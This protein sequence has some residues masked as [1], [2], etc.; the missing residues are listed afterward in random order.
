MGRREY[1]TKVINGFLLAKVIHA[2]LL[3]PACF[4]V[5]HYVLS[6]FRYITREKLYRSHSDLEVIRDIYT[7]YT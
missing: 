7:K 1:Y 2:P 4:F 6:V 5:L 3:S